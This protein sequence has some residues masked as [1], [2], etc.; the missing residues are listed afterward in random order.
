MENITL[1]LFDFESDKYK[2]QHF[3]SEEGYKY[4]DHYVYKYVSECGNIQYIF[5]AISDR[6][7]IYNVLHHLNGVV[8]SIKTVPAIKFDYFFAMNNDKF[9]YHYSNNK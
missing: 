7:R 3:I 2:I 1:G 6:F 8:E 5:C 4:E 9:L